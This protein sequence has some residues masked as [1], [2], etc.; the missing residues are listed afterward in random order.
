MHKLLAVRHTR[1]QCF[2]LTYLTLTGSREVTSYSDSVISVKFA[3]F[4][5]YNETYIDSEMWIGVAV[6]IGSTRIWA[7]EM[8]TTVVN[9]T[10]SDMVSRF[11]HGLD[12]YYNFINK[13][14]L[15][16]L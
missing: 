2:R 6:E 14:I 4:L 5:P 15:R 1:D 16:E 7:A 9:T 11:L 8:N 12:R 13:L 3:V 10:F